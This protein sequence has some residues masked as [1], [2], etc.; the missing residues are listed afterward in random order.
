MP[1]DRDIA[2]G[3]TRRARSQAPP[4][5]VHG[6]SRDGVEDTSI[7]R[8]L[9]GI[10][11]GSHR[12]KDRRGPVP[13]P[14]KDLRFW[15]EK[16]LA[17]LRRDPGVPPGTKPLGTKAFRAQRALKDRRGRWRV[18]DIVPPIP[19]GA[20]ERQTECRRLLEVEGLTQK[21]A[22]IWLTQASG[23]P[24]SQQ[25]VYERACQAGY[26]GKWSKKFRA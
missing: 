17:V 23:Q 19:D 9:M 18:G 21:D 4:P 25:K 26:P 15:D 16:S 10:T 11:R 5:V 3:K 22:A 2:K 8:M 20:T 1:T 12:Y 7:S 13:D 14:I 6:D 24:I